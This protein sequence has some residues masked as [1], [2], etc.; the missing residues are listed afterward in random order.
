M[1]LRRLRAADVFA[2]L[3]GAALVGLLWAPWF[4]H[5][6]AWQAMAV[7]DVILFVA[8]LM[9]IWLFVGTMASST[10]AVPLTTSVFAALLGLL[11]SVLAVLR[12]IWPPDLGPGPT[13]LAWGA[14]AGTA[15][16]IGLA[17]SAGVAMR[18]ERRTTIDIDAIPV[19]PA[20]S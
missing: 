17:L 19:T 5:A 14:W 16:V 11:G 15:A 8:G 2:G 13:D 1:D 20:P 12:L 9:G 7:N 10:A 18:S 4:E 6:T 3:F